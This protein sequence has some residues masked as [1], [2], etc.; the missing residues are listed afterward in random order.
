MN[1]GAFSYKLRYNMNNLQS[2]SELWM[3]NFPREALLLHSVKDKTFELE[4]L[5]EAHDWFSSLSLTNETVIYVFGIGS[6]TYY[7]AIKPWLLADKNRSVVFLEDDLSVIKMFFK[8]ERAANLLKDPQARLIYFSDLKNADDAF[9][10]LYWDFVLTQMHVTAIKSYAEKRQEV[11]KELKEKIIYDASVKNGLV[12]EYLKH[13]ISFF[14]NYY[15]NLLLL[16]ESWKGDQLFGKFQGVPAIICGAGPSLD[17]NVDQIK[18]LLDKAIVF[19][20]G[21]AL[22]ALSSRNIL[23]HFGIGIDPNPTQQFRLQT[24]KAYE[25][26]LFYRNRLHFEAF[27]LIHGP[28]LYIYGAGGYDIG[29]YFDEKFGLNGEW[30]DEGH[31]VVNFGLELALRLGCNPILLTGVDLAYTDMQAYAQGVVDDRRIQKEVLQ[32]EDFDTTALLKEDIYGKPI[33]TLWKWIAESN[34]ISDFAKDH[35][36]V[37]VIN[38]TEGGLGMPGV[39]NM[40]LKEAA[41]AYFKNTYD[42]KGWVRGEILSSPLN[43]TQEEVFDEVLGFRDSLKRSIEHIDV[44]INDAERL[45]KEADEK[46]QVPETLQSGLAALAE[47][48]LSEEAGYEYL[49]DLFNNIYSRFLNKYL[50]IIKNEPEKWK[51]VMLKCELNVKRLVFL[52]EVADVN[53]RIIDYTVE[54]RKKEL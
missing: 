24:N 10:P 48:E 1:A 14:K 22:N 28:R 40:T 8:T 38:C 3:Q 16:S 50:H 46:K 26:P 54:R 11:F 12:E 17:K 41:A 31:N 33:Y 53:V 44:L 19:G 18:D 23:P 6:G 2:N 47:L 15:S 32:T 35:K 52:K 5:K 43:I 36:D 4:S 37:K 39:Q 25:V 29:D 42:L 51:Q 21:S 27:R 34:W 20:G 9:D 30:I 45:S 13:G 49:L 7:D